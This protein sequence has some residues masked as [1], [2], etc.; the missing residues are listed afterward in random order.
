GPYV[1][2][3]KISAVDLSLAPKLY[4]LKVALGYFKKW[5]VPESLTHVHNYMELLFARE[6]FQKTKTPKDEYLI[7]GWEPKVNA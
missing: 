5:S 7:A 6:S 1:N 2:G 3:E 4:H